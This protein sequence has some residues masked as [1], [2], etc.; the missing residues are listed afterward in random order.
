MLEP[1]FERF[2]QHDRRALARL[3]SLLAAGRHLDGIRVGVGPPPKP[4]RVV[5][6]TGSGGVGKSTLVGKLIRKVRCPAAPCSATASA[7]RRG[8]TTTAST[9]AASPP[10]PAT[11]PSPSTCTQ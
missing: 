9:S 1:L 10:R 7:C 2:G 6:I 11:A 5:A 8:P 4:A 3:L